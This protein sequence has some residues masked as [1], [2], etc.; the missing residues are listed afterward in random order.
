[1]NFVN[2]VLQPT[3]ASKSKKKSPKK[4]KEGSPTTQS[5][6]ATVKFLVRELEG[7]N[8]LVY[9]VSCQGSTVISGG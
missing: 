8:D 7:H 3:G 9:A 6:W 4:K 1:M 5:G 2:N